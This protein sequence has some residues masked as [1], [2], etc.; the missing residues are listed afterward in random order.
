VTPLQNNLTPNPVAQTLNPFYGWRITW[1]LAITQTTGY[2]VLTYVFGVFV[3]PM[4]AELGWTRT[5]TSTAFSLVLLCAGL[6]AIP[7]GRF[8]D[9]HGARWV[10]SLGS[11]V[12]VLLVLAWS[13]VQSLSIFYSIMVCLGLVISSVLYDVAFTVVAVWFQQKRSQAIL[14]ITLVAGLA[15]TIFIPL[16]TLLNETLGWRIALRVLALILAITVPLHALVLR[17]KPEDLGL[18]P[19]GD[20]PI[21]TKVAQNPSIKVRAALGL[22]TF[23]LLLVSFTLVRFAVSVI[24]PHLVPL[25]SERGYSPA[26]VAS[27]AGSIGLVQLLGRIF[28]TPFSSRFPLSLV[29]AITFTIHALGLACL[30]FIPTTVGVW[31]FVLFYGASNGAITL[32]RAALLAD[33]FGSTNYG[34]LNGVISFAIAITGAVAPLLAGALHERTGDYTLTLVLLVIMASVSALIVAQIRNQEPSRQAF[35]T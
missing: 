11:A 14:I 18:L 29:A 21:E 16:A 5:Q 27:A 1:A 33:M 6:G 12:G 31:L 22:S 24:T 10:M 3:K 8:V 15:S 32:A 23:W 28:F 19:D 7:V 4:E 30:L 35:E 20:S 9:K 25:L 26:L 2:G 34:Q 17:R 13:W